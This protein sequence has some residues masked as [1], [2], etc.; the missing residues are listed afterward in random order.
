MQGG[1]GQCGRKSLLWAEKF[2]AAGS[3]CRSGETARDKENRYFIG[4]FAMA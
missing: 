1:R 4:F 2:A 3:Y